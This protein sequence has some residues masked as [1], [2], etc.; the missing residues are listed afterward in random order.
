MNVFIGQRLVRTL[1]TECRESY[2][3]ASETVEI[4]EKLLA[5]IPKKAGVAVPKEIPLLYRARGCEECH[6]SGYRGR[7]GIF[8][9]FSVRDSVVDQIE[10][11]ASE[12]AIRMAA[13]KGRHA[14]HESRRR[15]QSS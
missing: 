2:E 10:S 6:F 4:I 12:H 1:C 14:H 8:E 11:G 3:P 7:I 15:A 13:R 9:V 5:G